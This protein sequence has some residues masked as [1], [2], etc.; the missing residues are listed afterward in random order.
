[1]FELGRD[2]FLIVFNVRVS[3]QINWFSCW[4]PWTTYWIGFGGIVCLEML[5]NNYAHHVLCFIWYEMLIR[6]LSQ[7]AWHISKYN[8]VWPFTVCLHRPPKVWHHLEHRRPARLLIP[9][10]EYLLPMIITN[11]DHSVTISSYM[12]MNCVFDA[13]LK[14]N[15][16]LY[17][18]QGHF[19]KGLKIIANLTK[20]D[21][22]HSWP[23][24]FMNGLNMKHSFCN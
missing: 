8:S 21:I 19:L 3:V 16:W 17:I 2:S 20:I 4:I 10:L 9:T 1:M 6:V 22:S 7:I 5:S 24:I 18:L 23:W 11:W 14:D 13:N 12:Y 15:K